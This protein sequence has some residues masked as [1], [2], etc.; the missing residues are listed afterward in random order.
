LKASEI[1]CSP[2]IRELSLCRRMN[3]LFRLPGN[4]TRNTLVS[5]QFLGEGK[6]SIGP[7]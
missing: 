5:W 7:K 3:S 2:G 6:A 4:I 1:P